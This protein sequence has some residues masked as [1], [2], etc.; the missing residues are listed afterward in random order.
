MANQGMLIPGKAN[1]ALTAKTVVKI[2][3]TD[4][5]YAPAGDNG[6]GVGVAKFDAEDTK[7]CTIQVSG[8]ARVIAG[9]SVARGARVAA[10]AASKVVTAAAGENFI[11]VMLQSGA[12]D[13]EL[14]MLICPGMVDSDT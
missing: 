12:A 14:D 7:N 4:Y 10:D 3:A 5:S 11:G 13:E 8:V 6:L 1:G 2:G 9:G